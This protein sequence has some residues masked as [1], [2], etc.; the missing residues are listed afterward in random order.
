MWWLFFR[1]VGLVRLFIRAERVAD[2][3]LH[4]DCVRAMLP[5]FHAAGHFAY[6]KAAHLYVQQMEDLEGPMAEAMAGGLFTCRRTQ[7]FWACVWLDLVIEQDVM[8]PLKVQGGLTRGRGLTESVIS[9]WVAAMP[10]KLQITA[11]MEELTGVRRE[12][13][14][15][16]KEL[17]A[18]REK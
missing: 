11:A 15:Q 2:W 18:S 8:R 4:L 10:S 9:Q 3:E 12:S 16:H 14:D 7:K 13:S 6:A 1:L 17:R 5:F